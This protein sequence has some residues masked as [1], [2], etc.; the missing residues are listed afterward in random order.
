MK[1]ETF[2]IGDTVGFLW[3]GDCKEIITGTITESTKTKDQ[4][5]Q[6]VL[7]NNSVVQLVLDNQTKLN[8]TVKTYTI[9]SLN[10]DVYGNI[11]E[12]LLVRK[13]ILII[14]AIF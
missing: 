1:N 5:F 11:K 2:K 6:F 4:G 12:E 14:D 3:N 9:C 8:H 7:K 13:K 10:K